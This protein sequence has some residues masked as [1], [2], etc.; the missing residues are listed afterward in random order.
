M[1]RLGTLR[2][3]LIAAIIGLP[4]LSSAPQVNAAEKAP[5]PNIVIILAD[6]EA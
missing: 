3:Y 6:D 4:I 1:F 2:L 5:L